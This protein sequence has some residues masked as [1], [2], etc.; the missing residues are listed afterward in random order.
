M[1]Y[2]GISLALAVLAGLANIFG[3]AIVAARPWSRAFLSTFIALGAGFML[4][5]VLMEMLPESLRLAPYGAPV[6]ILIGYLVVHFFEHSLPAHFHFGEETHASEFLNPRVA[7]TALS[8]LLI[9]TFFDGV[10]ITAGFIVSTWLGIVISGAVIVHNTPEGFTI[11]SIMSAA[12]KRRSAGLAAASALGISRIVGVFG[13]AAA[14][15]GVQYGLAISAG[16]TLY[17]AAS[18]LI[19]EVNK[20]PGP[21]VALTVAAGVGLVV[22]LRLLF[23]GR[24]P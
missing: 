9:H 14:H 7:Y 20:K 13:M 8:G 4:A 19:P 1:R 6:L 17:V 12:G 18:D 3:A 21:R 24:M 11:A 5:T 22:L 10:A 23:F 2:L 15:R 16:V